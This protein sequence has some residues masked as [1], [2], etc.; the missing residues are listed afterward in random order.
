[1]KST[2][3]TCLLLA[4][5]PYIAY[6]SGVPILDPD[7]VTISG[8]SSGAAMAHQLH[9]A[10]PEV[11]SGAAL[12][13]GGPF[14]CAEGSLATAMSRCMGKVDGELPVDQLLAQARAASDSGKLGSLSLLANDPVWVFHGVLD[15][16]V[17]AELSEA[18]VDFYQGL[19]VENINYVNDIE[20]AHT[21]PTLKN[22]NAC[23]TVASP[24]VGACGY[25]A[26]G[27]SLQFLYGELH[28]PVS[29][30]TTELTEVTLTNANSAGLLE[31]AFLFAPAACSEAKKACKA[32]MV[33][34]GCNQSSAQVGTEFIQLSGYLEWAEANDIVLAFPQVAVA[35]TNPFAC[36]DWWGYTG[37]SYRWRDGA[38]MK[39]LS[40]WML[41][42]KGHAVSDKRAIVISGV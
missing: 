5:S 40:D 38:Q 33:L 32:Q 12:L 15:N 11:F 4:V 21:F 34:H 17:A 7:Q 1:M 26:A 37:E 24:F 14:G 19:N 2:V 10:Y 18:I 3:F 8:A 16:L 20:A 9:I 25:D 6:A 23:N 27:E 42:L 30:L 41:Q 29:E 39:V 35:A 36:W 31:Q 28:E 22:G 13:A